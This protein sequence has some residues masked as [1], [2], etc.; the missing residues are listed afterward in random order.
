LFAAIYGA[1]FLTLIILLTVA[2]IYFQFGVHKKQ[3]IYQDEVIRKGKTFHCFVLC[4]L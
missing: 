3:E 4:L 1:L 2:D